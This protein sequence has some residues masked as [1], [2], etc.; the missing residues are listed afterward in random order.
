MIRKI[1]TKICL[2][3][4]LAGAALLSGC[5]ALRTFHEYARA[6]DTVALAAG[7]K[8]DFARDK[9]TVTI[10]PAAGAPQVYLPGDPA[11]RAVVNLYADPV[12]S[13]VVSEKTKQDLTDSARTYGYLVNYNFTGNDRDWYETTVFL[14]L[15][16]TLTT[17]LATINIVSST[18]E[19]ASS[20][21]DIIPGTGQPNT[22]DAVLS[23][24]LANEQLA[25]LERV[26]HFI[27]SFSGTTAPYAMQLAFTHDPDVTH[28]GWGKPYVAN[29]RGDLKSLIWNDD[30]TNLKVILRPAKSTDINSLKD[31]K[32]YVTGGISG[33]AVNSVQ[34]FDANGAAMIGVT[35]S[36]QSI[37]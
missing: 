10:T 3:L 12:S 30:G 7:W 5:G 18:G 34:A 4:L 14:D 29:P 21:L 23:G 31:F 33:L 13:M 26:P 25:V 17:G 27:V 24:P 15:P 2:C 22:F 28:G 16:P 32:F 36:I 8:H 1:K 6:G 11:I 19:T 37:Q 9:I 20:T 35:A